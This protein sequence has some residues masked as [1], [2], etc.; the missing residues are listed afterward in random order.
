MVPAL[1]ALAIGGFFYA[2][3]RS[4]LVVFAPFMLSLGLLMIF[5]GIRVGKRG[6]K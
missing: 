6:E 5:V 2:D 3:Y 1:S 4:L